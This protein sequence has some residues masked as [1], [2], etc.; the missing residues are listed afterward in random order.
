MRYIIVGLLILF[1]FAC[2]QNNE[3]NKLTT[4]IYRA[5]LKVNETEGLPFNFEVVSKNKLNIFNAE[6][7]IEVDDITYKN[8]SVYI[9][10][11]VF[12]GYLVAKIEND[13]LTGSFVKAGLNRVMGFS[14]EKNTTRFNTSEKPKHDVSGHW[15]TV[16][17]PDSEE[18]TYIAKGIFSQKEDVVTGTFRTTTGDYRYLEGVLNGKQL[19]LSTFDGA[20]AF[21]FTA[22]VTDS[23]MVGTFYSGNHF[24]EPFTAKRNDTY[25]LPDAN[26]LTFLKEGYDKVEFSFPD[27]NK[28]MVSLK[29][30]RFKDKVVLVQ[31]MGTW[32]PNCLDESKFYSEFYKNNK[33][34]DIEIIALA[35]EY[36]KTEESAFNNIRRLK[37]KTGITYPV[38]LAQYGSSSKVKAQEKL[39]MLNHVLSYPTTIFID[40]KGCVRKIHTGFNGPA[41]EDRYVAFKELFEVFV[42]GLLSE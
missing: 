20:H 18:D 22:S 34:K 41:T 40:K 7:I 2:K 31:I 27:E 30:A 6:E 12:E 38:L 32:C 21:L 42:N 25:E 28:T 15:E 29:D 5:S 35:F 8:D 4:G 1:V 16:F 13:K 23:S 24:Q 39:P 11:A 36:A 10:M 3:I 14:A 9:K 37:N 26:S 33:D 19:K 17:S